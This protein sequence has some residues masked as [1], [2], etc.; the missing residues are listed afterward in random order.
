MEDKIFKKSKRYQNIERKNIYFIGNKKKL[1]NI[2]L[3][4]LLEA[5]YTWTILG[6]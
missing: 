6:L 5:D 2:S 4:E 1:S 3:P